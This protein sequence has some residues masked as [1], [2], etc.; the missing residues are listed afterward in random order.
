MVEQFA[1][2]QMLDE[3]KKKRPMSWEEVRGLTVSK[4]AFCSI[5]FRHLQGQEPISL[6]TLGFLPD[7]AQGWL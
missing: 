3:D 5:L 2:F 6:V 7:I 4:L 1:L